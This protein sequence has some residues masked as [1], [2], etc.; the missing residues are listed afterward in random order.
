[1][2]AYDEAPLWLQAV[3]LAVILTPTV[4]LL[5]LRRR[6]GPLR[7]G[8]WLTIWGGIAACAEHGMWAMHL[9][10]R[11]RPWSEPHATVHYYMA[12]TYTLIAG[13]LLGVVALTLLREGRPAGW[14]ALV[15]VTLV[16]GGFELAMNGPTGELYHHIGLYG[17]VVAWLAA[18]IITYRP[19]DPLSAVSASQLGRGRS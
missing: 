15:T 5:A 17:Y 10:I 4:V 12:G 18:L 14:F 11:E 1:M 3:A 9:A 19:I 7:T 6:I 13:F 8:A 16:G 2:T